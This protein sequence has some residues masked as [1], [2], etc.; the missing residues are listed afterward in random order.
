MASLDM[1]PKRFENWGLLK[2]IVVHQLKEVLIRFEQGPCFPEDRVSIGVASISVFYS[3]YL[4]GLDIDDLANLDNR[5]CNRLLNS[6]FFADDFNSSI[7][8]P[9]QSCI[10]SR[11]SPFFS[12]IVCIGGLNKA[13]SFYVAFRRSIGTTNLLHI[14]RLRSTSPKCIRSRE[15]NGFALLG[16]AF[17]EPGVLP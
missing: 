11:H 17:E 5:V 6:T 3:L 8:L 10:A 14:H 12:L 16:T 1:T 2:A 7:K 15:K 4:F 9:S 13:L